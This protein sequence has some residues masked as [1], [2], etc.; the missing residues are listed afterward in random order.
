MGR[1]TPD[2]LEAKVSRQVL[3]VGL[4]AFALGFTLTLGLL[5]W[6]VVYAIRGSPEVRWWEVLHVG[7]NSVMASFT[8]GFAL[9]AASLWLL[10]RWQFRRGMRRCHFCGRVRRSLDDVC[11]CRDR[12]ESRGAKGSP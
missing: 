12:E 7:I 6:L 2:A 11:D 4:G 8:G 5:V 1:L 3:V 10:G 9:S